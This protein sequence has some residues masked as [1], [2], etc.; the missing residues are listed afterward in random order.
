MTKY[1][2]TDIQTSYNNGMSWRNLGKEYGVSQQAIANARKRG[3]LKT[4]RN[5]SDAQKIRYATGN[6]VPCVHNATF[7]KNLSIKQSLN[8]SGGRCKWYEVSGIKVQG[9]WERNIAEKFNE[10]NVKWEKVKT[11]PLEYVKNNK[12]K[13]YSPDFYLPDFDLY[14]EIKGYWWGN[15]REKMDLIIE[16]NPNI[17]IIIIEKYDYERILQGELVWSFQRLSEE[18]QNSVRF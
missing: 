13:R 4:T 8:N 15:D 2:W 10:L 5:N 16:Q 1:S 9:T 17:K 6:Y 12:I 3:V 18:Q 7:L 11:Y 14:L